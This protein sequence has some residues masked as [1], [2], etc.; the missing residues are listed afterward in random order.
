[1]LVLEI[2]EALQ[3]SQHRAGNLSG[4]Q[5]LHLYLKIASNRF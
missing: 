3:G 1:M 4:F 2:V 5:Q